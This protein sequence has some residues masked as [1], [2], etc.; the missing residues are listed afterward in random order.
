[1]TNASAKN[2]VRAASTI[3]LA[4]GIAAALAMPLAA[5]GKAASEADRPPKL[6]FT[7]HELSNG[8][9]V[10]LLE[11]HEVP[12]IDLQIW[13]HVGGKDELPG[14][15]GFAH[16]F[17]HLM[18]KGSAHVG[19]DEHSRIIEAVGG[20]DNAE[21]ND[22][23]TDFFETFPSQYLERVLWLEADRMGSLNVDDANFKS[24]RQVVEEER[25]VRVDNQPYGSIEE[26]LRAA[27]FTVHGYHH[28]PIGSIADLDKATL[29]DVRAFF[30]TY[31][32][33]NNAT[34]VI[35]GDF[36]SDQALT[37]TKKYFEG[38]PASAGPIPR[39]N[40]PEPPQ[41]AEREVSKSYT[42]TP[43]PAVVI[44]Y[45]IP[46]RYSP[47]SYPLDLASNILAGGESSR[48]Y[49]ALVYK[50]QIAVQSAGFG[51]FTEDPNL[52]W[53]Y[54]IMNPRFKPQDGEKAVIGIL[55]GLKTQ[56]VSGTEL[57]KAK[58]QEISGFILGRDTD[59]Q[60]AI[61]LENAAVI[62]KNPDLVNTELDRYLKVTPEDIER[63]AKEYFMPEHA[64]I[65]TITP[66][67]PPAQQQQQ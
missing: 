50:D 9:K 22:D 62:G 37:W 41:T 47:D 61:A 16:L 11:N 17:E 46:A 64:T 21:T 66:A 20:F 44:G 40:K 3:F 58:N 25:R 7:T 48:L 56:P 53:A 15:T 49:Q 39:P 19:P 5:Q 10:I 24:E 36:N 14:H 52:F 54:A 31:Y 38:I 60:K 42:N 45:K 8:L 6:N 29:E 2:W 35:V 34:L 30:N 51:N 26:D 43:L 57:Q 1:M 13:Y 18:F 4:A 59:E 33:P 12:V 32:K 28:T 67:A 23:S 55:D 63:V 27:A 65:L